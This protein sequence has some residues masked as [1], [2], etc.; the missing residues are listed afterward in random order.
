LK[1]KGGKNFPKPKSGVSPKPKSEN[2]QGV[3]F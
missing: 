2:F 1:G 3:R